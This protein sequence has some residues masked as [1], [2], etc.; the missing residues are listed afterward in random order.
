MNSTLIEAKRRGEGVG[1]DGHKRWKETKVHVGVNR[2]GL[3]LWV[4]FGPGKGHD[5]R[6]FLGWLA[7]WG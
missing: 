3:P 5:A 6:K 2:R 7:G 4:E 1:V